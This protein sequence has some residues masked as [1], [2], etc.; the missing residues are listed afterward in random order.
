MTGTFNRKTEKVREHKMAQLEFDVYSPCKSEIITST[1]FLLL[2]L[3]FGF[4]IVLYGKNYPTIFIAL[5]LVMLFVLNLIG[6]WSLISTLRFRIKV[7]GSK[8]EFRSTVGGHFIFK[9]SD[10]KGVVCGFRHNFRAGDYSVI[11][12]S[13]ETKKVEIPAGKIGFGEIAGYILEKY[14]N[15]EINK[16]AISEHCR[17]ELS[18]LSKEYS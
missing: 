14:E 18:R 2:S 16:S 3:F 8:I 5:L 4:V 13:M 11:V 10:I 7:N 6:V 12:I 1:I 9:V 15:G 17:K